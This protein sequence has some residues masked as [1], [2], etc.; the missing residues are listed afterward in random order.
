MSYKVFWLY[1]ALALKKAPDTP[2]IA[3]APNLLLFS[4]PSSAINLSS[5]SFCISKFIFKIFSLIIP[6]TLA[7]AVITPFPKKRFLSLSLNSKA[8]LLP[9]EAPLGTEYLP[10]Y[11]F[12]ITIS[13][14]TVGLPLESRISLALISVIFTIFLLKKYTYIN[15][16]FY[17]L[18]EY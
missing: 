14:S 10:K 7:T 18:Q 6:F 13:T 3:F 17:Y 4:V 12:S 1:T 16:Y 8:S 2:R 9:T 5:S 15:V 11:L